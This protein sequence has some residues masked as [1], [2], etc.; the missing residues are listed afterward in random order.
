M[1]I[2]SLMKAGVALVA[3]GVA[4]LMW[5]HYIGPEQRPLLALT[6]YIPY[7]GYLV[8]AVVACVA[9]LW[10]SWWWRGLAVGS[11]VLCLTVLMGLAWGRPDE[12]HGRVRFMTYNAKVYLALQ[13][14]GGLAEL[15]QEINEQQPDILVMQDAGQL[16]D[17]EHSGPDALKQLIGPRHVQ[18]YGQYIVASRWPM[19]RCVAGQIPIKG[20]AHS[21][22]RC[23]VDIDGVRVQ[24]VTVHL[25]TPRAGLNATRFEGLEGLDEWQDNMM[26]RLQQSGVLAQYLRELPP[27]PVILGGDLNAPE[28]SL[29]VRTLLNT[30][31]RDAYSSASRGYGFTHGH[32]MLKGLSFL[33]LDHVLVSPDI[34]VVDAYAGGSVGSQHRPVVADLVLHRQ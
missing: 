10:L 16:A 30:G 11:L 29:V 32:H 4:V 2:R 33:R 17:A 18:H 31:L 9:S 13:R 12:G 27:G 19:E 1:V 22:L 23:P 7:P 25:V 5:G 3:V 24:V 20:V 14:Q 28:S 15:A 34:G 6:Q 21:F 8:P 26:S